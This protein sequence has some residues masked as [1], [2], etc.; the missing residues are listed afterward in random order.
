MSVYKLTPTLHHTI[1]FPASI[2][3]HPCIAVEGV[4]MLVLYVW[5]HELSVPVP[6]AYVHAGCPG[7]VWVI[8]YMP[9]CSR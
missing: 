2:G 6:I 9:T 8:V 1:F 7:F 3:R 5:A 4:A